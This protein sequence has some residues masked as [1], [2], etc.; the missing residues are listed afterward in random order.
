MGFASIDKLKGQIPVNRLCQIMDVSP[1]G[2]S[3]VR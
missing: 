3:V 2:L 1:R